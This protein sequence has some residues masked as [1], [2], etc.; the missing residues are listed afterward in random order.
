M[1]GLSRKYQRLTDIS[2]KQQRPYLLLDSGNALFDSSRPVAAK[3]SEAVTARGI[4]RI[5][6]KMGYDACNIGSNDSAAGLR[7]LAQID[8]IPWVSIHFFDSRDV[9]I[10]PAYV[11]KSIAG[12]TVAIT[13]V[14]A[15]PK[16]IENDIHYKH[17]QQRL[18]PLLAEME[19]QA[20][21]IIVLSALASR[22][23]AEIARRFPTVRLVLTAGNGTSYRHIKQVNKALLAQTASRGQYLG[24]LHILDPHYSRW[25]SD[26][27]KDLVQLQ[28]IIA[29]IDGKINVI[30]ETNAQ[31]QSQNKLLTRLQQRK[32]KLAEQVQRLRTAN[33]ATTDEKT[34]DYTMENIP[35]TA[36]IEEHEE[37]KKLVE[38]LKSERDQLPRQ[39]TS[40]PAPEYDPVFQP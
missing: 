16:N 7:F 20:D 23:N 3:S 13:G 12:V 24:H 22:D 37:I 8:N 17:W 27:D 18:P 15:Q 5:Y 38:L 10:F 9:E 30:K 35:L 32:S 39:K 28:A 4:A 2:Q 31:A 34:S 25:R 6:E 14:T 26:R 29:D 19:K 11:L 36:T 1:G 40:A 33:S 21:F